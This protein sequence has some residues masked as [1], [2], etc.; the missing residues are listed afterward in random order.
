MLFVVAGM[1]ILYVCVLLFCGCCL[2]LCAAFVQCGFLSIA[3]DVFVLFD[4][5]GSLSVVCREFAVV[6]C[7]LFVGY[8]QV[9]LFVSVV[10]YG[11]L[12][13]VCYLLFVA[14]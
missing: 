3:C 13:A 8:C 4:V 6:R 10:M 5:C 7:P 2:F 12:V 14:C 9:L 1:C 11:L